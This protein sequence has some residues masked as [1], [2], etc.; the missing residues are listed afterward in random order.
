MLNSL[1][2]TDIRILQLLQ[3]NARLTN[4]EIG[5]R[6]NKTPTPIYERIKKLQEQGYIKGYVAILDHKKIDRGLMAFTQVQLR[7][8]SAE[9]LNHFVEEVITFEE[10]LECYQMSGGFDFFLRVAVKDLDTYHD[11]LMKKLFNVVPLGSVQSTF[12]LKEAKRET[13]F[14]ITMPKGK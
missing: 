10:V 5:E 8:H 11:F 14:P 1:D 4:K 9:N 7:D 6:L 12:V 2:S 13:S 3:E